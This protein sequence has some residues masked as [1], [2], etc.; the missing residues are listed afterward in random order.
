MEWQRG[1]VS[2]DVAIDVSAFTDAI[3]KEVRVVDPGEL[4]DDRFALE[5]ALH[6]E[7][8]SGFEIAVHELKRLGDD[9][10]YMLLS[11]R[12]MEATRQKAKLS[13]GEKI[14][15]WHSG[16]RQ[17][18]PGFV[19]SGFALADAQS[20]DLTIMPI[21]G[22]LSGFNKER[23][24]QAQPAFTLFAHHSL[25]KEI[26]STS[27]PTIAVA[28]PEETTSITDS[29]RSVYELCALL[30]SIPMDELNLVDP[31]DQRE[32]NDRESIGFG[33]TMTRS[34]VNRPRPSEIEYRV[35]LEHVQQRERGERPPTN[36][37]SQ[38]F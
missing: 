30:E 13:K 4:L 25:W 3:G 11:F 16:Q 19:E 36:S 15:Q 2:F 10:Y 32:F 18:S 37:K 38:A 5:K 14:C 26:G 27:Y 29:I 34:R 24:D 20:G 9:R 22:K 21:I 7:V 33:Q 12:P 31:F 17:I 8:N 35:F 28:L 6:R 23:I 1:E